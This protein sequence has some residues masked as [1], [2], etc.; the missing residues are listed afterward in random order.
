MA[1]VALAGVALAAG[2]ITFTCVRRALA[3]RRIPSRRP[4]VQK[5]SEDGRFLHFPGVTIVCAV[6]GADDSAGP[7]AALRSSVALHAGASY[8]PLPESSY[9]VTVLD[10]MTASKA[11]GSASPDELEWEAYLEQRKPRLRAAAGL[12]EAAAFS[13]TLRFLRVEVL[14]TV[15]IAEFEIDPAEVDTARAFERRIVDTL[16][17]AKGR[18]HPFHM[19]L[20]YRRPSAP[21]LPGEEARGA[22]EAA[23]LVALGGR[24]LQ[25]GPAYVC[26]FQD[27]AAWPKWNPSAQ[28][29]EPS[30]LTDV[31][32]LVPIG[33]A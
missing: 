11:L 1:V 15:V 32:R 26:R 14:E 30:A 10:V 17:V 9:H 4:G 19:T 28:G 8:V 27:L 21:P 18:T 12:L 33:P 2:L 16:G 7:W 31:P 6:R 5:V 24:S 3:P 13:P 29:W 25:L 20:G 23:I 22:L